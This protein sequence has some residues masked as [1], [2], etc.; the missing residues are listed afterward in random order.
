MVAAASPA[1]VPLVARLVVGLLGPMF[2]GAAALNS[3]EE[4]AKMSLNYK[5][6]MVFTTKM[7]QGIVQFTIYSNYL[8]SQL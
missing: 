5:K 3:A 8:S 7:N 2:R 4:E 6:N 1:V